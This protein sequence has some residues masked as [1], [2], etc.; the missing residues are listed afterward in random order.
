MRRVFIVLP[1]ITF[2]GLVAAQSSGFPDPR[3]SA[4]KVPPV[5]FRSAFESY[6]PYAEQELADWRKA[7]DEVGAAGG[8]MGHRPGQAPG[9]QTSKPQPGRPESSAAPAAKGSAP[10]AGHGGHK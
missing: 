5:E 4:V 7:N 3:D 6:R 10:A 2:A 8:H 1:A 9:T